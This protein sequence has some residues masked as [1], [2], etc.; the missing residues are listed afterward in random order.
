MKYKFFKFFLIIIIVLTSLIILY[1]YLHLNYFYSLSY[2]GSLT[3]LGTFILPFF[4]V[5]LVVN[6]IIQ[7]NSKLISNAF[8]SRKDISS[9]SV[10]IIL[11]FT[12]T[13]ILLQ[14]YLPSGFQKLHQI[15]NI[16]EVKD[17]KEMRFF[18]VEQIFLDTMNISVDFD[19][20]VKGK[21][22][23]LYDYSFV[24]APIISNDTFHRFI[25]IEEDY[26]KMRL[27]EPPD[28]QNMKIYSFEE[29]KINESR[30][31][32]SFE[33]E[34]LEHINEDLNIHYY[35]KMKSRNEN[36]KDI[37]LIKIHKGKFENR[38]GNLLL[39][40]ILT[41]LFA[42]SILIV[43]TNVYLKKALRNAVNGEIEK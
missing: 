35:K 39:W 26:I 10:T 31:G 12:I 11:L 37:T 3:I 33:Y 36:Y 16:S 34:Y 18:K 32:K 13:F 22:V 23:M 42:I 24:A 40:I 28:V 1:S 25:I 29:K 6:I 7:F 43:M 4:L 2:D 9:F 41:Y 17:Y 27:N 38:T 5:F 15:K 20:R 8:I 21:G 19:M 14:M 30:D